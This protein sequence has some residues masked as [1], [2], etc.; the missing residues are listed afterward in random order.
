VTVQLSL[1]GYETDEVGSD[2]LSK[3]SSVTVETMVVVDVIAATE[4]VTVKLETLQQEQALLHCVA[5]EQALAYAGTGFEDGVDDELPVTWTEA[6]G[7]LSAWPAT[8]GLLSA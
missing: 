4:A 8:L 1:P 2:G 3:S 6:P 7:L 5:S